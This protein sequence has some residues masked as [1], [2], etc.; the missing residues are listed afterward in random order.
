[1]RSTFGPP[2][3]AR[4]LPPCPPPATRCN[5]PG[6]SQIPLSLVWMGLSVL[7]LTAGRGTAPVFL[8][9]SFLAGA[10]FGACFV[11]YAAQVARRYGAGLVG[12]VY[13]VVFLAYGVAALTGPTSPTP[14]AAWASSKCSSSRAPPSMAAWP[15]SR[16]S[17]RPCCAP[18]RRAR[19]RR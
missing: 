16:P 2:Q 8:G 12:R 13:P 17:A 6:W 19:P 14:T 3:R 9:A 10:G 15:R 1:M 5:T 18:C 11:L 7:A 4:R